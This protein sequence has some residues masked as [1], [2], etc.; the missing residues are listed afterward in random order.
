VR[1]FLIKARRDCDY[2]DR[3]DVAAI[4]KQL[5]QIYVV[6]RTDALVHISVEEKC[7]EIIHDKRG[8]LHN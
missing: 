8:D 4:Q 5:C 3:D 1:T 2:S 6:K 7:L